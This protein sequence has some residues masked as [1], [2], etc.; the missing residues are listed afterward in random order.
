MASDFE[1]VLS[2]KLDLSGVESQLASLKKSYG[3]LKIKIELPN[4]SA[5]ASK[6][7]QAAGQQYSNAFSNSLKSIADK[8]Q[9]KL[10]TGD[11]QT[12]LDSVKSKMESLK[13]VSDQTKT[14]INN[15]DSAFKTMNSSDA[16]L[17]EKVDAYKQFNA[18]LPTIKSQLTQTASEE[19]A[20]AQAS[21]QAA[22]EKEQAAKE[23]AKVQQEAAKQAAQAEKQAAQES[24]QAAKQEAQAIKEA[25]QAQQTLT[26]SATLSNNM[27]TWLNN[28]AK[29]AQRYGQEIKELQSMLN[30]NTDASQLQNIRLRFAEI[31][32]EAQAAG[33]TTNT[34][35]QSLANTGKQLLGLTSGVMVIRQLISTLKEGVD[36]I[37]ELDT[38]LVD[39][40]KTSDATPQQLETFYREANAAAKEYGA[41]T[42]DIIQNAA[43]W[44]RLGYNLPDSQTMSK[45]TAMFKAI[46]PS[47]TM[48]DAQS[49]LVS[50]MKAFK[51]EADDALDG[52]MSKINAVG[53]GFALTNSDIVDGLKVSSASMQAANNDLEQTIALITAGT[54]I[55][56]D[57]SRV[58]NGLR[59]ISM[60]IRGMN[61]ETEELDENLVNIKGDV[62]ELTHGK[63]S[64]MEDADT[65]KSTYQVLKEVSDVW[66]ELAD[67]EQADLLEK[68]FG[69]TRADL[70]PAA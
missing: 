14:N 53:N 69:K 38:A 17:K 36:T 34:F 29:A 40:K 59:T 55:T 60:R 35:A 16:S 31:K 12:K 4:L 52:I 8:M 20:A 61:E 15:L 62:A 21:K 57:A 1:L 2:A 51:I 43:D 44:S 3:D 66:D 28:N 13:T 33:L 10:D 7:G 58:G 41:T 67:K 25:A 70:C 54:E 46:S 9:F 39:L 23:A 48:D 68:L 11:L 56:Q 45:L 19:K 5:D 6:A 37:V 22:K 18:L 32:S 30:G 65:Y 49:G 64:I 42:K 26:K 50:T 24:A 47:M 27:E 63:V